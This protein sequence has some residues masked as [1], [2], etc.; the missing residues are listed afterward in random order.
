MPDIPRNFSFYALLAAAIGVGVLFF[1]V[2]QPFL[3]PLFLAAA[4]ALLFRPLHEY[5]TRRLRGHR[6]FAALIVTIAVLLLALLPL[7]G[8]LIV[9][10]R[11]LISAGQQ[12]IQTDWRQQPAVAPVLEYVERHVSEDDWAEWRS[13][14]ASAVEGATR[15]LYNRTM[16]LLS[17][18]VSFVI[19]LGI[20]ALAL[21]YF[22][23]EGPSLLRTVRRISPLK[24]EDEL[25]LFQEFDRVCRSVVVASVVCALAQAI[26]A[27]IGFAVLGV[28]RVWLLAGLTMF[29]SLIPFLG[30]AAVWVSVAVWLA[31]Q[32]DYVSA[33]ILVIYGTTIVST[34]DN[35]IRAYVIHGTSN[36][37]PLVALISVLGALRIIG[38][39]GVFV[40]PIVAAFFYA[41]LKILHDRL[42]EFDA[43]QKARS[44]P[45][46]TELK[47]LQAPTE[48]HAGSAPSHSPG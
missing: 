3:L 41:L 35:L 29:S 36:L 47:D 13:S 14:A 22:L 21:F 30:S 7:T 10:G 37:H 45:A 8:A 4:L 2:V 40:G 25:R 12:L 6:H 38:L 26:L 44:S 28:D 46:A 18:I 23:A 32:G 17:N 48:R 24:G 9:A 1:H 15:G 16:A 43:K 39:W 34:S 19:G 5:C 33:I 11:E 42:D 20:V 27:G 31:I